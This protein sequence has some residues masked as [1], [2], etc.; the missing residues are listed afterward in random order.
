LCAQE[1]IRNAIHRVA[2]HGGSLHAPQPNIRNTSLLFTEKV[3]WPVDAQMIAGQIQ[4]GIQETIGTCITPEAFNAELISSREPDIKVAIGE[5]DI[6]ATINYP[7]TL[8]KGET[9][10]ASSAV[11]FKWQVK[12]KQS[13]STINAL[14][15]SER[16]GL[17]D[18]DAIQDGL[19][20]TFFPE[21]N[22]LMASLQPPDVEGYP[23]PVWFWGNRR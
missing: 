19:K 9:E 8:K 21:E 6:T 3:A 1:K 11:A 23:G 10:I 13:I 17:I 20:A 16:T 12:L 4:S 14:T 22:I 15:D 2:S 18:I 5:S 7:F